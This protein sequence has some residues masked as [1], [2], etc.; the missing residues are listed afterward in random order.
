MTYKTGCAPQ[1]GTLEVD[2]KTGAYIYRPYPDEHGSDKFVFVASDPQGLT[3]VQTVEI[4]ITNLPDPPKAEDLVITVWMGLNNTIVLPI[5]DPD[6][7]EVI[8]TYITREPEQPGHA[9]YLQDEFRS[10][11]GSSRRGGN[12]PVVYYPQLRPVSGYTDSFQFAAVAMGSRE[13][14]EIRTCTLIVQN[15]G[16]MNNQP[17]VPENITI[18]VRSGNLATGDLVATDDLTSADQLVYE[19][20]GNTKLGW[21]THSSGANST[22]FTYR[23]YPGVHGSETVPYAVTDIFGLTG[24]AFL[25]FVV[26]EFNS[27]PIPACMEAST[28]FN[29][30]LERVLLGQAGDLIEE[31]SEGEV[32]EEAVSELYFAMLDEELS[33]FPSSDVRSATLRG[34]NEVL[35]STIAKVGT[36][37]GTRVLCEFASTITLD[38]TMDAKSRKENSMYLF[39][40]DVDDEAPL[41]YNISTAPKHGSIGFTDEDTDTMKSSPAIGHPAVLHYSPDPLRRGFPMD[42]FQ[43]T[44]TDVQGLKSEPITVNI[45]VQQIL[46]RAKV[47]VGACCGKHCFATTCGM[48]IICLSISTTMSSCLSSA[49]L[50]APQVACAPGH[51]IAED[52]TRCRPCPAGTFNLPDRLDQT[53]CFDCPLGSSAPLPG[54]TACSTCPADTF[55]DRPGMADCSPCPDDSMTSPPGSTTR[56][57]CLCVP[58]HFVNFDVLDPDVCL[59]C[60]PESTVC[61]ET[62]QRIP[63]PAS[64]EWWV[65]PEDG[66]V[67]PCIPRRDSCVHHETVGDTLSGECQDGYTGYGCRY[68]DSGFYR[69]YTTFCSRC[70]RY[71]WLLY[72][73]SIMGLMLAVPLLTY[74]SRLHVWGPINV[75]AAYLQTNAMLVSMDL[76]WPR[77]LKILYALITAVVVKFELF[78]PQCFIPKSAYLLKLIVINLLPVVLLLFF[79]PYIYFRRWRAA[80]DPQPEAGQPQWCT[81]PLAGFLALLSIAYTTI[82]D[83]NLEYWNCEYSHDGM[84][85]MVA[86]PNIQCWNYSEPNLHTELRSFVIAA[87]IVYVAGIPLL[88]AGLFFGHRKTLANRNQ[89]EVILLYGEG[90]SEASSTYRD[91]WLKAMAGG[92]EAL[93]ALTRAKAH[94]GFLFRRYD[95]RC[96]WWELVVLMK[97]LGIA[98]V[99]H[100]LPPGSIEQGAAA[101]LVIVT[102][103]LSVVRFQPYD[104]PH[105]DAMDYVAEVMSMLL[106]VSGLAFF[107]DVLPSAEE[108]AIAAILVILSLVSFGIMAAFVAIDVFPRV[109][110]P[111]SHLSWES[112]SAVDAVTL[113]VGSPI[114]RV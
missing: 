79:I 81:G 113:R 84:Y 35:N 71:T 30:G 88:F 29:E 3:D 33:S 74:F 45:Q 37:N 104:A 103:G 14:S 53:Q 98:L 26:E 82:I 16:V 109:I 11:P 21:I 10:Q 40:Y 75:V 107:A 105:M 12:N 112:F 89:L 56:E 32:S 2:L 92:D 95:Q 20:M 39:A 86:S 63:K 36:G 93:Q 1:K 77:A 34:M 97:K 67:L 59:R 70:S 15:P 87:M 19:V 4:T 13:V 94:F 72:V 90:K 60:P 23:S 17:P 9:L 64:E 49:C 65:A 100:Q 24:T 69:S 28:L 102:Y 57:A 83:V 99:H 76:G 101:V 55:A 48:C 114:F 25:T 62:H 52:E 108:N 73:L 18:N 42:S 85:F 61:D 80:R 51:V 50:S 91:V 110:F 44:A 96:F 6:G 7:A 54:S 5:T 8:K 66:K 111:P 58:G 31:A 46:R 68:C 78:S 47:P 106:A 43:W 38:M 22:R 41:L 27:A